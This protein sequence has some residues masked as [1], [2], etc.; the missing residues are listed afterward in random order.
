MR[1]G[2]QPSLTST[3]LMD[4]KKLKTSIATAFTIILISLALTSGQSYASES[5]GKGEG[6]G[7]YIK[8]DAF[9]VNLQGL[10][11]YLQVSITLMAAN[12][13]VDEAVKVNMPI[14]RH[15]LILLLSS[16]EASQ[17]STFEGKQAL[18]QE[19]KRAVNKVIHLTDKQGI[20]NTLFESFI[21]Q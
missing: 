15:E 18:L 10:S 7:Q 8:L 1:S 21:I 13:H 5:A 3:T 16:K 19:A 2:F 4:M 11:Q 6:G 14:I 17:I 12:P 20:A 9:T